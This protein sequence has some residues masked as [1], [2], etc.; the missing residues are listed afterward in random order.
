MPLYHSVYVNDSV[1]EEGTWNGADISVS[2]STLVLG[3][4]NLTLFLLNKNGNTASNQ[5]VLHI[6]ES[7]VTTTEAAAQLCI[8]SWVELG[9]KLSL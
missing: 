8:P 6:I 4:C 2:V 3:D 9:L 7:S 5:L 1:F